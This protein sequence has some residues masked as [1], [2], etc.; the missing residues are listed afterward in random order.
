MKKALLISLAIAIGAVANP[1]YSS[2]Y[3]YWDDGVLDSGWV[4]YTGGNY[5][6]VQFTPDFDDVQVNWIGA[7]TLPDWPDETY[8]GCYVHVFEDLGGY[9]GADLSRDFLQLTGTG[10]FDWLSDLDVISDTQVFYVAFEQVGNYPDTDSMGV[11][12]V[13]GTHDWT[14]YQGSWAPTTLF[15]DFMLRCCTGDVDPDD[16]PG[17]GVA[18][19]SWGEL[20]AAYGELE[21]RIRGNRATQPDGT[22]DDAWRAIRG[23]Y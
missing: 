7:M 9:P 12:A 19:A 11:D 18:A 10:E 22:E 6:A 13:A 1:E 8:Q 21:A 4:W 14:G 20:K 17:P 23:L 16:G 15:G 5:W 3:L 2:A